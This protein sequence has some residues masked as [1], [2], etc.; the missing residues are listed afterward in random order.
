MAFKRALSL[1]VPRLDACKIF[2]ALAAGC[3]LTKQLQL[4]PGSEEH[5]GPLRPDVIVFKSTDFA[6]N[7]QR[8][9]AEC[10]CE[11]ILGWA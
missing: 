9:A 2:S 4:N 3:S 11:E 7:G 6:R 8:A 10:E 5:P 1:F